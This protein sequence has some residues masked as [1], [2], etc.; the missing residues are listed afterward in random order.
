MYR[1]QP[2]KKVDSNKNKLHDHE[3]PK[4]LYQSAMKQKVYIC[5]GEKTTCKKSMLCVGFELKKAKHRFLEKTGY[6]GSGSGFGD[7]GP[8]GVNPEVQRGS[9]KQKKQKR[10]FRKIRISRIWIRI[11]GSAYM[12]LRSGGRDLP[13][14]KI[15]DSQL[16]QFQRSDI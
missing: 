1:S 7:S 9:Q 10:N 4:F 11:S 3:V 2:P 14:A 12:P 16:L 8:S 15:S 5:S 13:V 6:P